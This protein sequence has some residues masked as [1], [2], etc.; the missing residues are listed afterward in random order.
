MLWNVAV[1]ILYIDWISLYDALVM[2]CCDKKCLNFIYKMH[3]VGCLLRFIHQTN[4][5]EWCSSLWFGSIN[6]HLSFRPGRPSQPSW[7]DFLW[8]MTSQLQPLQVAWSTSYLKAE[9]RWWFSIPSAHLPLPC[10]KWAVHCILVVNT[11]Q[12]SSKSIVC[13]TEFHWELLAARSDRV[14]STVIVWL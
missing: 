7:S 2:F 3:V 5:D 1:I 14:N 4:A 10:E 8:W 9:A 11:C 12:S 13:L 6:A